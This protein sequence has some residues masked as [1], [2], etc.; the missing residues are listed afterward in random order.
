MVAFARGKAKSIFSKIR[1]TPIAKV[2]NKT[3]EITKVKKIDI[4]NTRNKNYFLEA[5]KSGGIWLS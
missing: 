3:D 5:I 1:F 2:K 4:K